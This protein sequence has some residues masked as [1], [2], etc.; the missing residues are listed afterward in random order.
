MG[1]VILILLILAGSGQLALAAGSLAIPRILR[2]GA[3][4]AKLRPLTRQVFWTYAGYIWTTNV[5]FGLLSVAAPYLLLDGSTLARLVAGYITVY[6][7]ARVVIQF[8]YFDRTDAP[9]GRL[10]QLGEIALVGLFVYLTVVYGA[11][12]AGVR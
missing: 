12:A 6:W 9:P 5:A 2:W 11:V 7:A 3:D 1:D 10:T 4:T 8:T